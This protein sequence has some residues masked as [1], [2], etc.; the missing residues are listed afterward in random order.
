MSDDTSEQPTAK[1]EDF[2][3]GQAPKPVET[4]KRGD[5]PEPD[6]VPNT[7]AAQPAAALPEAEPAWLSQ[8]GKAPQRTTPR[9]RWGGIIWGLVFVA[10]GWFALW[11]M[12]SHE[13]RSAFSDWILTLNDGGWAI[14]AAF[15]IGALLLVL[16]LIAA[17]RAAT[18][19]RA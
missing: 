13:R 1:L 16:G 2:G 6:Q 15:A 9:I 18:R 7:D 12:Q 3:L 8:W 11:T 14:V 4:P 5:G 17:L 10:S 19:P